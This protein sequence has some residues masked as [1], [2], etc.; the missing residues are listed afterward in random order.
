[1]EQW[2]NLSG[3]FIPGEKHCVCERE[4]QREQ[5]KEGRQK[6]SGLQ[7]MEKEIE[8]GEKEGLIV[9]GRRT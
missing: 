4:V 1:M 5:S 2:E 9:G 7:K 6:G 8:R 3:T